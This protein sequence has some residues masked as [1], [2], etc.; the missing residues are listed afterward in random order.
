M[1]KAE[2]CKW[3]VPVITEDAEFRMSSFG[4]ETDTGVVPAH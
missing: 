3:K 1:Y 2:N 4:A